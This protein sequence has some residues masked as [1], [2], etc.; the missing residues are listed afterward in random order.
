M[1]RNS[2]N[3]LVE[4]QARRWQRAREGSR[5]KAPKP[6]IAIS[7]LPFSGASELAQRLAVRLDYGIFGREIVDEIAAEEGINKS[8]VEGLDEHVESAIE[9]HVLDGFRQRNFTES[10]YLRDAVRIVSTLGMRGSTIVLGRGA[11][12]I[13]PADNTLRVL[14]VAPT[15]WRRERMARI[16][17]LSPDEVAERLER[18]DL[19]RAEFWKHHFG[20]AHTDPSLYDLVV[21]SG[22]LT[23]DGAAYLVEGAFKQRFPG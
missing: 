19:N 21:N 1:A 14:V 2:L 18:E 7:R 13:L 17:K 15:E 8:L 5:A 16:E 23:I 12:C 3:Q 6:T 9:R 11:V 20:V 10:D 22:T 4:Q